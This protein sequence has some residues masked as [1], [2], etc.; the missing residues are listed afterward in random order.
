M[1]AVQKVAL[2]LLIAVVVFSLF[3]LFAFSGLFKL[4]ESN[5]YDARVKLIVS[6]TLDASRIAVDAYN[7][8]N[9]DRFRAILAD[10]SVKRIY[11]PNQSS[12]DI[13][14][15]SNLF[16][17]LK[18]DYPGLMYVRF[19]DDRGNI[20]FS[21][22]GDDIQTSQ[23]YEIVYK[24]LE[25]ADPT[26]PLDSL[27]STGESS[28]HILLD[29]AGSRFLYRLPAIDSLGERRGTAV[30]YVSARDLAANLI[31]RSLM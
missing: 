14:N 30:F 18:A 17:K 20:H 25:K 21:T 15:R 24:T 26:V 29:A 11:S 8:A 5:F 22:L 3:S 9:F 4:I 12:D 2:S 6:G 13:F 7:T 31:K 28:S 23:T 1:K 10:D 27:Q 19:I 16:E